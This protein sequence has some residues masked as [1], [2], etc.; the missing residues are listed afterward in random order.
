MDLRSRS[1][2]AG[3]ILVHTLNAN[4]KQT[5]LKT[6]LPQPASELNRPSDRRLLAKSVPTFADRVCQVVNVTDPYGRVSFKWLFNCTHEAERTPFQTH[7]SEN[8]AVPGIE[9]GLM[10]L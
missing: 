5:K 8:L 9:H 10:D 4:N 2:R 6:R 1:A 3:S 7:Y